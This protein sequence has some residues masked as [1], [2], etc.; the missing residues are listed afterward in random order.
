MMVCVVIWKIQYT[1][2]AIFEVDSYQN[3]IFIQ[4][5]KIEG[6]VREIGCLFSYDK[7]SDEYSITLKG[8]QKEIKRIL[9]DLFTRKY[10]SA[11]IEI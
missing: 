9:V 3:Y 2:K 8:D 7:L 11:R 4:I 10:M 1:L 6:V 5:F